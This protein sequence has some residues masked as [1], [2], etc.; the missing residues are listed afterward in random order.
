VAVA[1]IEEWGVVPLSSSE[2]A[3]EAKYVFALKQDQYHGKTIF[4]KPYFLNEPSAL[5][6]IKGLKNKL[7]TVWY[8]TERPGISS[9]QKI[10]PFQACIQAFLTVAVTIY[11]VMVRGY[12][13]RLAI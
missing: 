13:F 6:A 12:F 5:S 7:W 3:I 8:N 2:F 9:L 10:F 4:K 1:H 11:F